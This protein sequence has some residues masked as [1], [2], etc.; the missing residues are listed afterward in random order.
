MFERLPDSVLQ[1]AARRFPSGPSVYSREAILEMYFGSL[2]EQGRRH[3][4]FAREV[5]TFKNL[6][7]G[8]RGRVDTSAIAGLPDEDSRVLQATML[9]LQENHARGEI[10][11]I[12]AAIENLHLRFAD[13]VRTAIAPIATKHT[14][15]VSDAVDHVT[16]DGFK[17]LPSIRVLID[18]A[19][20]YLTVHRGTPERA[21]RP[22]ENDVMD[23][24]HLR[25][26]PHV[27]FLV[28]DG[29]WAEAAKGVASQ[30]H[31]RLLR[32]VEALVREL[33]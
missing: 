32:N 14:L 9:K 3:A 6:V 29:F 21:R 27:D 16:A 12:D 5:T 2:E 18:L 25:N 15:K 28:T 8:W 30:H 4:D 17:R 19:R 23:L 24:H 26:L 11:D 7:L 1:E 31:P 22:Q 13:V 33:A 20:A 10:L